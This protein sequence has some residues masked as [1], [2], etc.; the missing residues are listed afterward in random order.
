MGL[1]DRFHVDLAAFVRVCMYC[2]VLRGCPLVQ[3]MFVQ[4]SCMGTPCSTD[5]AVRLHICSVY[6]YGVTCPRACLPTQLPAFQLVY[7]RAILDRFMPMNACTSDVRVRM[8]WGEGG[9]LARSV[10]LFHI[11]CVHT[12]HGLAARLV[13]RL[14]VMHRS[15][16]IDALFLACV[17]SGRVL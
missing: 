3:C 2:V 8:G 13:D 12:N 15:S 7:L 10:W 17:G 14:F 9:W 5:C 16:V 4:C 11:R 1:A 6:A